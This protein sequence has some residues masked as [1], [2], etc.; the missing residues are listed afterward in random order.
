MCLWQS[1]TVREFDEQLTRRTFGY[2][3]V[4]DYYRDGSC[5]RFIPQVSVVCDA[6]D[7]CA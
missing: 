6:R 7:G 1:K 2:A 4:D 5:F 3:G